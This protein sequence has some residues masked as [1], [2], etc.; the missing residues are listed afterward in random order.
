MSSSPGSVPSYSTFLPTSSA[1]FL[2]T[3]RSTLPAASP[4]STTRSTLPA[5]TR[6]TWSLPSTTSRSPRSSPIL[7]DPAYSCK[8]PDP[9]FKRK[10]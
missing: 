8:C 6:S 4:L 1:P 5:A 9:E 10:S 2:P 3:T 7:L